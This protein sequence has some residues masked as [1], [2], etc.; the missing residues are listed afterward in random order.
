[1]ETTVARRNRPSAVALVD[2]ITN[3]GRLHGQ[4][5]DARFPACDA[6]HHR[7]D[8]VFDGAHQLIHNPGE[9]APFQHADGAAPYLLSRPRHPR[10]GPTDM[11]V[12]RGWTAPGMDRLG[13]RC[14]GGSAPA[15]THGHRRH[16]SNLLVHA[17][18]DGSGSRHRGRLDSPVAGLYRHDPI[19]LGQ[20]DRCCRLAVGLTGLVPWEEFLL[21]LGSG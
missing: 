4:A 16:L 15:G 17:D 12:G 7:G 13:T 21:A 1:M 19:P 11:V 5:D 3:G 10:L 8:M 20:R 18:S 2:L 6:A 14:G 9:R